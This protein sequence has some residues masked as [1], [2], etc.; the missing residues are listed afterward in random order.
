MIEA[1]DQFDLYLWTTSPN[2]ANTSQ[3]NEEHCTIEFF[4]N[5]PRIDYRTLG[6]WFEENHKEI[7]TSILSWAEKSYCDLLILNSPITYF[8]KTKQLVEKLKEKCP[9]GSILHDVPGE[10]FSKLL[11]SYEKCEDWEQSLTETQNERIRISKEGG[12]G[13]FASPFQIGTDFTIYNSAWARKFYDPEGEKNN[14]L[15][16]PLIKQTNEQPELGLNPVDLTIVNPLPMKGGAL[17]LALAN[18]HFRNCTIRILAGGYNSA[19]L[20]LEPYLRPVSSGF[21]HGK[22]SRNI[23]VLEYVSNMSEIYRNTKVLLHPTRIEG[24][25]MTASEAL[26]ENCLVVTTDLPGI[27]EGVGNAALQM[28]YFASPQDWADGISNMIKNSEQWKPRIAERARFLETR[29]A[30][31]VAELEKYLTQIVQNN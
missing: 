28:P 26:L 27:I 21:Y 15:F 18:Y 9:V 20:Q 2:G 14:I 6:Q 5:S 3:R 12:P 7:F 17:F 10:S 13:I 30:N 25:G 23:E 29:Q 11:E 31:E 22:I 19:M 8:D 24:Y 4:G 16:H 1:L